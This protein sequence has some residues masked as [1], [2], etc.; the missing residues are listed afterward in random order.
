MNI[1]VTGGA[2]FIASNIVDAYIAQ[3]HRVTVIDNLWHG[4]RQN[5][6]PNAKFVKADIRDLKA[7]RRIIKLTRPA[8]IN[9]HAAIAEV[10]RS[11]Q[12]PLST[13]EVNVQGTINLLLA[14]GEQGIKKFIF[15]STGGAIYGESKQRPTPETVTPKPLSPYGLSKLLGEECIDYYARMYG[16]TYFIFRYPNVYGP[17]QDPH[18]EAGVV[19][20]F[21][22][23]LHA[24]QTTTIFGNGKKT[25]DYVYVKDIVRANV[26]ALQRGKNVTVNLGRSVEISD[27]MVYQTLKKHFPQAPAARYQSVRAGE[28]MRSCL[29]AQVAKTILGWEPQWSFSAGV[30][31]Y[32]QSLGYAV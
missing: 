29:N 31:D 6:N 1:L 16:F 27:T 7:M 8:I 3:G 12:D 19:A 17:R 15:A 14:G 9:H 23:L 24:N 11:V 13:V 26:L 28:V 22:D 18:G 21:S 2:G 5:L 25:R 20:I 32:L 10:V 30:Y 4:F